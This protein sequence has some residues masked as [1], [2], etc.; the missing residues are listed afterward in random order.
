M[1]RVF[2]ERQPFFHTVFAIGVGAPNAAAVKNIAAI[3]AAENLLK[4][5]G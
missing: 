3:S 4:K 2:G 5:I 1:N